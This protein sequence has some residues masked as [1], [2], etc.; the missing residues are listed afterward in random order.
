VTKSDGVEVRVISTPVC[1]GVT[2]PFV[3]CG[4]GEAEW[5]ADEIDLVLL[6]VTLGLTC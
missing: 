1:V 6:D 2:V 5:F 3:N 4:L